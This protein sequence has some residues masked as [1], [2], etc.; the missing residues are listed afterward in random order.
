MAGSLVHKQPDSNLDPATIGLTPEHLAYV[1]YT[2]GSTGEPKGVMVQHR[3]LS[4]YLRWADDAYYRQQ[5]SGSPAVHSI[6]FDGLVTTLFGPLLA[7]QTL[8][9]LPQGAEMDRLAH[10][11]RH[12][13]C[14]TRW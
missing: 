8:T 4:N 12:R 14:P 5:G 1:I 2:S 9:L 11:I 6:G 7:G 13:L 10:W 3:N